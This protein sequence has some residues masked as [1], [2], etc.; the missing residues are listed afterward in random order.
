VTAALLFVLLAL[1]GAEG[2]LPQAAPAGADEDCVALTNLRIITVSGAEIESGTILLHGDK[3]AAVGADVKVPP[4][5]KTIDKKGLTAFPGIVHSLSRLGLSE[6]PAPTGS[7][8]AQLAFDD[9]NPAADAVA[10]VARSG[11]TVFAIQP[12]GAGIAGRGAILKPVGWT[13][14][15]Q[16]I[17]KA[18]FL[19]IVLQPG[20]GPKDALK[21]ALEAARKAVD[22][23]RKKLDEKTLPLVQFL[24]GELTGI[25]EA[26]TPAEILHFWQIL[27]A[28]PDCTPRVVFASFQEAYKAAPQLGARKARVILRPFLANAPFTFERINTAAELVKAGAQVA[29]APVGDTPESLQGVLFRVSE[30]VKYGL[31]RDAALRALTLTPA[32]FLGIEKRVGS[33]EA[34]KDGDFLLLSGDPLSAQSGIREVYIN[35]RTVFPGE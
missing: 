19:R 33:I 30:L 27:D 14:E 13:R 8:A 18:A 11:V 7:G 17:E 29:F 34:G 26:A 32:E 31:P 24:K 1:S 5:A 12:P 2:M 9:L 28:M 35:G 3:I 6:G 25:V 20:S 4:G 16:V 23:D 15:Q 22:T 10:A 21:Q